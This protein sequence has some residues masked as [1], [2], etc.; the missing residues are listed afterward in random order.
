MIIYVQFILCSA[1]DQIVPVMKGLLESG[2]SKGERGYWW[3]GWGL[4]TE[5]ET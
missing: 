4:K 5:R 2:F 3:N 1:T